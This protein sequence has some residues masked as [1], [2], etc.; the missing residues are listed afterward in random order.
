MILNPSQARAVYDAMCALNN[1]AA[2]KGMV[3][4]YAENS[5]NDIT[6]SWDAVSV[7]VHTGALLVS[8][9]TYDDQVAFAR[10]YGVA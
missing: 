10:A 5:R 2:D 1:V 9:E 6:V 3:T 8:R 7:T 4:F